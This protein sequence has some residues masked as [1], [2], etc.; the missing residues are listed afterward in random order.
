MQSQDVSRKESRS[1]AISWTI[2]YLALS[3]L[4]I[5]TY[6]FPFATTRTNGAPYS[7]FWPHTIL[8]LI[9]VFSLF[10]SIIEMWR[11]YFTR[12]YR[13]VRNARNLAFYVIL[14]IYPIGILLNLMFAT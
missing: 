8:I 3:L 5:W 4:A 14:F 2:I 7:T 11:R 9:V 10:I 12:Q 1:F 6:I 13:A